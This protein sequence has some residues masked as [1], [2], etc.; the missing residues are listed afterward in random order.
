MIKTIFVPASGSDTD[1]SVFE[2]ALVVAKALAAH[3][4][5][6]HVRLTEGEGAVSSPDKDVCLG[7]ALPDA[8]EQLSKRDEQLAANVS[9]HF[10]EFCAANQISVRAT[11]DTV[12]EVSARLSQETDHAE[13]RL[14]FHVRHSD[15]AILGR[16]RNIDLMPGNL[17]GKLLVGSGRPIIIAPAS[18]PA[19]VT[20]TVVVGW[21]ET[22]EAT[23]SL[24]AAMPLLKRAQ[25]VVLVGV[26]E[27]T[28]EV[29]DGLNHLASQ[30][31]WHA[32]VAETHLIVDKS[33]PVT[34]QLLQAAIE[35]R[36]DLLVVGAFSRTPFRE[37]VFGGVTQA[38]INHA[39]IP[40]FMM[41]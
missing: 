7:P 30:L 12:G 10:A 11:P 20:G 16:P 26:A 15:L 14:M 32:I 21:K 28:G 8:F 22:A 31:A 24:G 2:T 37:V 27:E 36:A 17:I 3:L 25:R 13:R 40:V 23:R 18:P 19:S 41:H 33:I 35:L 6:Y 39:A 29:P 1:D 9:R 38:L 34:A 4:D 5:F